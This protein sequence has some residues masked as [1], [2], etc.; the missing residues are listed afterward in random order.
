MIELRAKVK[1]WGNSLGIMLPKKSGIKADQ[2]VL[3]SVTPLEKFS[4]TRDFFGVVKKKVNV[5]KLMRGI[6]RELE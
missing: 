4:K 5:E 6:D 3:V 2:D 1:K